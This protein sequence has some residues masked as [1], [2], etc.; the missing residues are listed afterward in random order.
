MSNQIN[1]SKKMEWA[2]SADCV[3]FHSWSDDLHHFGIKCC[4]G[5]R[6]RWFMPINH[7]KLK[8]NFSKRKEDSPTFI[9]EIDSRYTSLSIKVTNGWSFYQQWCTNGIH[10]RNK[11][12]QCTRHEWMGH[13]FKLLVYC[14]L[15]ART[16]RMETI[17]LVSFA[18]IIHFIW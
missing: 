8:V 11:S 14:V 10:S 6:G 12:R 9:S 18:N 1:Y 5:T 13:E 7:R 3:W 17:E 16:V 2:R 15:D 4:A